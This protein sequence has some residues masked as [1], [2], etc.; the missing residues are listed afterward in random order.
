MSFF[1]FRGGHLHAEKVALSEIAEQ[2]GT[3]CYVYSRAAF[4]QQWHTLDQAFGDHPHSICYAVKANS[5][6]AVLNLL[7]RLGSGFDIVSGGELRRVLMAKGDPA[8][9]VFSGV[10]KSTEEL[11]FVLENGVRNINVESLAELERLQNV[12]SELNVEVNM[13]LRVN[14]DVDAQ[15]HPYIA[16]GLETSKF[17]I[18]MDDA[19]GVYQRANEMSHINIHGIACHIGSQITKLSPFND[20]AGLLIDLL[21]KLAENDLTIM[22]LDLGG[23]LGIDSQDQ[24]APSAEDYVNT[25]LGTLSARK[26]SLPISIEPGRYIAGN[27]GVLITRVEYLKRNSD[28]NFAVVDAGMNDLLRPSLYQAHHEIVNLKQDS[29]QLE[30]N[31]DVVGPVC[32]SSDVLGHDRLLKVQADDLIALLSAGAYS[33]SMASNYNSRRRPAEVMVDGFETH[34]IRRRETFIELTQGETLLPE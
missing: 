9:V 33:F 6:I 30:R 23:G 10:A 26:V 12:A 18:T 1:E 15:T 27:S 13:A 17:G 16:T 31:Y 21:E 25:L 22:Q 11:Q 28:K 14:P 4:E 7:A 2:Y 5:N 8:K 32:E 29:N 19:V 34:L 24:I 20:T 3:P